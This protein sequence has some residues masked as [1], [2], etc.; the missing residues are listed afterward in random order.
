MHS[1][2]SRT[3]ATGM[4]SGNSPSGGDGGLTALLCSRAVAVTI[5]M[6]ICSA[7]SQKSIAMPYGRAAD[8]HKG[9]ASPRMRSSKFPFMMP[10]RV[11]LFVPPQSS[12]EKS[13]HATRNE[14][15][16]STRA[17]NEHFLACWP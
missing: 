14:R 1:A 2:S 12:A 8:S 16:G 13:A 4:P 3:R 15:R 17:Q 11:C 7:I 10:V 6:T 9:C 5:S